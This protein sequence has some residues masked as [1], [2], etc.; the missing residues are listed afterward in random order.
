MP[1]VPAPSEIEAYLYKMLSALPLRDLLQFHTIWPSW[2]EVNGDGE[3]KE[4]PVPAVG[5]CQRL[6]SLQNPRMSRWLE[7]DP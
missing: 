4:K 1:F 5:P 2:S 3:P 6:Q 7:L